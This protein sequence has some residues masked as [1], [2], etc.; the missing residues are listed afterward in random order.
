[1]EK[2]L[3]GKLAGE[4]FEAW[5]TKKPVAP[6]TER[7]PDITVEEAY[8]IQL[9]FLRLK[10][11]SG[12]TEIGKK[13]GLTSE[14][15]R[16]QMGVF[17]PDYSV[18]TSDGLLTNGGVLQMDKFLAPRIECEI[19]FIMGK[20]FPTGK[21]PVT[22]WDVI[23]ATAGISAAFEIVD[24]RFRDWKI[25]LPD[26]VADLASYGALVL[27]N[28]IVPL[29][30]LDLRVLGMCAMKNGVLVQN[31]ASGSVM[32]NPVH[33][34]CWLANKLRGYGIELKA[35]DVVLSGAFA[36]VIEVAKGDVVTAIFD[37][38]GEVSLRVE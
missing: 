29:D 18:I 33:A 25:K 37:H 22:P 13:I 12:C 34:V 3:S 4:L 36:P 1:M 6:L 31:G 8:A 28:R 11:E 26:T 21:N 9:D 15:I 27:D 16:K 35:G 20:D 5:K 14:G 38:L 32:G 24:S 30:G 23:Q 7:Y 10:K 17:E 19:A 2:S